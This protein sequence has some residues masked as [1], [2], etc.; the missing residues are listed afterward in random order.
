MKKK[1]NQV[2]SVAK[3]VKED[4]EDIFKKLKSKTIE[5]NRLIKMAGDSLIE[6]ITSAMSRM[7]SENEELLK[8]G[9]AQQNQILLDVTTHNQ[10]AE[11]LQSQL[12]KDGQTATPEAYEQ[13]TTMNESLNTK[14][15]GLKRKAEGD[16]KNVK[17]YVSMLALAK[18]EADKII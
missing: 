13:A 8:S 10:E 16:L 12:D 3:Q 18:N 14:L 9:T 15:A 6:K 7:I 11:K 17:G 5:E 2:S 4:S 1:L